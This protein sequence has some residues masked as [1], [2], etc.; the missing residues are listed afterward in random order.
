M[1]DIKLKSKDEI[2][3]KYDE[4]EQRFLE[5]RAKTDADTFLDPN[6]LYE[7]GEIM[8]ARH[9]LAWVLYDIPFSLG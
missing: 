8:K 7:M 2:K 1:R 3:A 5:L 9:Y 6:D 4:L